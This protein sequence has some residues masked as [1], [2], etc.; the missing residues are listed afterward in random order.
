MTQDKDKSRTYGKDP[1]ESIGR[2]IGRNTAD[3]EIPGG[4]ILDI[5]E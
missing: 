1:G 5:D 4:T 2:C 3:D